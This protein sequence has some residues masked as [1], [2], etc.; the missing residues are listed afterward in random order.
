[1]GLSLAEAVHNKSLLRCHCLKRHILLTYARAYYAK[2]QKSYF[3]GCFELIQLLQLEIRLKV[4]AK[5]AIVTA[6][7]DIIDLSS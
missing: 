7:L 6:L 4:N 3:V 5:H 2:H 1:M